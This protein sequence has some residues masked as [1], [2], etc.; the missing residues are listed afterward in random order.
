MN[1]ETNGNPTGLFSIIGDRESQ[2]DSAGS[3]LSQDGGLLLAVLCDGMGGLQDGEKASSAAVD[4]AM[5]HFRT[6]PPA[7]IADSGEWLRQQMLAADKEVRSLQEDEEGQAQAGSTCVAVISDGRCFVWS[8]VGDSSIKLV[9]GGQ[10]VTLTRQHNYFLKLDQ[11]LE[12]GEISSDEYQRRSSQGNALISFLGKGNLSLIDV[13]DPLMWEMG[14]FLL[15]CSDGLY[16]S[17]TDE[18][19][20]AII[21][22][23]GGDPQIAAERLCREAYRLA[24]RSQ[25]NT[26]AILIPAGG[27][28]S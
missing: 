11:M 4:L 24:R 17:L 6:L 27:G 7:S 22:E 14:D 26:T 13:S 8:C 21:D 18:Q 5:D 28:A 15:L 1:V 3:C 19:I 23:A 16:K 2:Q 12:S 9:R 20:L 25:D 10:M